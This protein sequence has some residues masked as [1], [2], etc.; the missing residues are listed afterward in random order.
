MSHTTASPSSPSTPNYDYLPG[1]GRDWLLPVYDPLTRLL[2]ISAAHRM[3][4]DRVDFQPGEDALEV[5]CGTGNLALQLRRLRPDI[6]VVGM[7]PDPRALAQAARKARR[8]GLEVRWDRG[9]AQ[10]LPYWDGDF[11]HVL[12]AFMFHHL[13]P[14]TRRAMLREVHR[15]LRPGGTLALIDFGGAVERSDGLVG[16]LMARGPRLQ[17]NLGDR[18]P[19]LMEQAGLTDCGEVGHMISRVGRFTAYRATR[20][21]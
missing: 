18:L 19:R 5:G 11:D 1:M 9:F 17:D 4:I 3:L 14:D 12:S 16:R 15:V 6:T 8:R 10:R 2:R 7:D 13:E 20:G 21:A